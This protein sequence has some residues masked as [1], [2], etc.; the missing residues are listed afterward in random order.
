MRMQLERDDDTAATGSGGSWD[1]H[2]TGMLLS[3]ASEWWKL[4]SAQELQLP[5]EYPVPRPSM[6]SS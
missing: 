4:K 2:S 5:A 6:N 3:G 1:R